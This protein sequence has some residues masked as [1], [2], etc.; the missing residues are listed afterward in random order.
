MGNILPKK[1]ADADVLL[2]GLKG[3]GKTHMLM[4]SKLDEDWFVHYNKGP[5]PNDDEPENKIRQEETNTAPRYVAL[6]PT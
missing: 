4:N 1:T 5:N 2:L 6:L 3:A